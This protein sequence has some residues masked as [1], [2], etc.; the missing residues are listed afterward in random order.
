MP[1]R[2]IKAYTT[3]QNL[4]QPSRFCSR[5]AQWFETRK[6]FSGEGGLGFGILPPDLVGIVSEYLCPITVLWVSNRMFESKAQTTR[7]YA[8]DGW[9]PNLPDKTNDHHWSEKVLELYS[10]INF[11]QPSAVPSDFLRYTFRRNISA[12]HLICLCNAFLPAYFYITNYQNEKSYSGIIGN[13]QHTGCKSTNA[14][15][16]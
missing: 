11:L 13:H 10:E 8:G 14:G 5:I 6:I 4:L 1:P 2:K 7:F 15:C 16:S 3:S 9:Q 12:S